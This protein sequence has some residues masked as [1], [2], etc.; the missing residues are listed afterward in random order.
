V[1]DCR[2]EKSELAKGLFELSTHWGTIL[3]L[4]NRKFNTEKYEA[5]ET[6]ACPI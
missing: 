4:E 6:H 1:I 2:N 3:E 5:H